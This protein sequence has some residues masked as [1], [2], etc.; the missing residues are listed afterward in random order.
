MAAS[1]FIFPQRLVRDQARL[2]V[3]WILRSHREKG[4][5]FSRADSMAASISSPG[6]TPSSCPILRW[7]DARTRLAMRRKPFPSRI[8]LPMFRFCQEFPCVSDV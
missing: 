3:I 2:R 5:F 4:M 6:R 1:I 8:T 7:N